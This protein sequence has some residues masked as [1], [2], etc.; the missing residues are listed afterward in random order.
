MGTFASASRTAAR[1]GVEQ[2]RGVT[3][4]RAG[5]LSTPWENPFC[6]EKECTP[7]TD[8]LATC[9]Y[10]LGV[11]R[12]ADD[13]NVGLGARTGRC[14]CR[15]G[16]PADW[17]RPKISSLAN[18]WFTIATLGASLASRSL[19]SRPNSTGIL[20]VLKE[21]RA[22]VLRAMRIRAAVHPA[23]AEYPSS[24]QLSHS[25]ITEHRYRRRTCSIPRQAR[26]SRGRAG[27]VSNPSQ[28]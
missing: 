7:R 13:L 2:A 1:Q 5:R 10:V 8:F 20:S 26:P 17:R 14:P 22:G 9:H 11:A 6:S 4:G 16:G 21:P 28:R 24:T 12:H 23:S 25:L 3:P 18:F 15:C 27:G 19:K